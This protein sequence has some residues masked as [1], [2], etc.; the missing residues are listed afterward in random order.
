MN[1]AQYDSCPLRGHDNNTLDV[2]LGLCGEPMIMTEQ[3]FVG[4]NNLDLFSP[5]VMHL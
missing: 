3:D 5:D 1:E 4:A 2:K